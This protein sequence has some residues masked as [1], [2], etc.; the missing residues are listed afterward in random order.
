LGSLKLTDVFA[1][2]G[3]QACLIPPLMAALA[4]AWAD[5]RTKRI[6]PFLTLGPALAGLGCGLAV[7]KAG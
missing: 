7:G 2:V 3:L 5:L 6:P 1:G 4:F